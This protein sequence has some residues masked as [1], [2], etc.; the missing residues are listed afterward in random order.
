[1]NSPLTRTFIKTFLFLFL[2]QGFSVYPW[3]SWN[4]LC[5]SGWP[6]IKRSTC[7]CFE[8]AGIKSGGWNQATTSSSL[9]IMIVFMYER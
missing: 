9:T 3:L 4:L 7:L 8:R 2:K 6:K 1:M 5:R